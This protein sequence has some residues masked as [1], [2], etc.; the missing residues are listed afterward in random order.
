MRF[1]RYTF[2]RILPLLAVFTSM[3]VVEALNALVFSGGEAYTRLITMSNAE[4]YHRESEALEPVRMALETFHGNY[5]L[6]DSDVKIEYQGE[7]IIME[8]VLFYGR[9]DNRIIVQRAG[10]HDDQMVRWLATYDLNSEQ[11]TF[12]KPT[13][14]YYSIDQRLRPGSSPLVINHVATPTDNP[15]ERVLL[16]MGSHTLEWVQHNARENVQ[17]ISYGYL[18]H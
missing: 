2:P 4:T 18:L 12:Y 5:C 3:Y 16:R 13:Y 9:T 10:L 8:D 7:M 17:E 11:P 1:L 14:H 15:R 6:P